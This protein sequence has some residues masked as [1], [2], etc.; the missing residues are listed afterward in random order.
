[1][2]PPLTSYFGAMCHE[3]SNILLTSGIKDVEVFLRVLCLTYQSSRLMIGT[4]GTRDC[5]A[6][7]LS[8]TSVSKDSS[9]RW[10]VAEAALRAAIYPSFSCVMPLYSAKKLAKMTLVR[11]RFQVGCGASPG[12]ESELFSNVWTLI[13]RF[14]AF[15]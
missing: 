6:D 3:Q 2:I 12:K 10:S 9:K 8:S 13:G 15:G 11:R 14:P 5:F 4:G 1:M 7:M